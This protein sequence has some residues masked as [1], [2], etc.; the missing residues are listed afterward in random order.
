MRNYIQERLERRQQQGQDQSRN[1]TYRSSYEYSNHEY[2]TTIKTNAI[3]NLGSCTYQVLDGFEQSKTSS[4]CVVTSSVND[5]LI[6]TRQSFS[7]D[8]IH[9]QI[10]LFLQSM[11]N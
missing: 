6:D 10:C 2:S 7:Y 1:N 3:F 9:R 4:V 5:D 8:I 11:F